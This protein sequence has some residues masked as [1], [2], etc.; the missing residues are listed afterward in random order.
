M[1]TDISTSSVPLPAPATW[2]GMTALPSLAPVT[3][4]GPDAVSFL[5]GQITQDVTRLP[6]QAW[7]LGGHCSA[8][9]RMQAS[10]YL[11]RT[12]AEQL[13]LLL[14][15]SLLPAWLKRLQMFVL[16]AK[17]TL[18]D[19]R[20]EWQVFG[21][22]GTEVAAQCWGPQVAAMPVNGVLK[23]NEQQGVL[24]RLPDSH[25]HTRF[26]WSGPASAAPEMSALPTDVWPWLDVMS[27]VPRITQTTVDQFVPQMINFE[28]LQGVDFQKG[29]Y[30]G[31]E[32]VARSQ[33]RGTIKRRL[34]L[35]HANTPMQP[36]QEIFA[37]TDP[38][39]PAGVIVNAAVVPGEQVSASTGWS[40]LAEL[41][42]A[43]VPPV[44]QA[45]LH[46]GQP[47]GPILRVGTLPYAL[48]D[49]GS[50]PDTDTPSATMGA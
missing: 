30:P 2:S 25:G 37:S 18:A 43:H 44:S 48:P 31:Q 40:A 16:R 32:V 29:C 7:R 26:I 22:V 47:D 13:L 14:D 33:Y 28:L 42:L 46:L 23:V 8:K 39:Q 3:L 19:K 49:H 4:T 5:Q 41:K 34:F 24:L 21:V 11:C 9:G 20:P 12:E 6:D 50:E 17:V 15:A 10:F 36:M 35:V 1:M 45:S 27:G 38:S